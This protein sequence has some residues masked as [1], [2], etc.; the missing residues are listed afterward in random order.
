MPDTR[1][2]EGE[3]TLP[4]ADRDETGVVGVYVC[5]HGQTVARGHLGGRL[6]RQFLRLETEPGD[7]VLVD[8]GRQCATYLRRVQA[9]RW[10]TLERRG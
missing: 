7:R 5:R 6:A 9:G 3:R 8:A 10:Q 1:D 4:M 2:S